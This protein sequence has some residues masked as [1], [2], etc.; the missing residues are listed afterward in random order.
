MNLTISSYETNH[1]LN[2]CLLSGVEIDY[3]SITCLDSSSYSCLLEDLKKI[4][5]NLRLL[6]LDQLRI[7][8]LTETPVDFDDR[9]IF[10]S[11]LNQSSTKES[12]D[13]QKKYHVIWSHY[14]KNDITKKYVRIPGSFAD[15]VFC[16]DLFKILD[17]SCLIY[18]ITRIDFKLVVPGFHSKDFDFDSDT[19]NFLSF[20]QVQ[21]LER[22]QTDKKKGF[23]IGYIGKRQDRRMVR[24]YVTKKRQEKTFE[25]ECKRDSAK[26]YSEFFF[27]RNLFDFNKVLILEL[28]EVFSGLKWT[29]YSKPLFDWF[30]NDVIPIYDK[31]FP[32][33]TDYKRKRKLNPGLIFFKSS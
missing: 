12:K 2:K 25:V 24:T 8:L 29:D 10:E 9:L 16:A 14:Y 33:E 30:H 20:H 22:M 15:E 13:K 18:S 7:D 17:W 5:P 27:N 11:L 26:R 1:S 6:D 3:L 21:Q 32:G 4:K 23:S 28:I 19:A 31:E